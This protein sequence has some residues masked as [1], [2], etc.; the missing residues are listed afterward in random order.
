MKKI[1]ND[2]AYFI[3]NPDDYRSLAEQL[4]PK[5]T[6]L[7]SNRVTFKNEIHRSSRFAICH[8][9][10]KKNKTSYTVDYDDIQSP[11]TS[12]QKKTNTDPKILDDS[13]VK[14]L[15]ICFLTDI[16]D[17]T[18]VRAEVKLIQTDVF[19][20]TFNPH[21][22]SQFRRL[23]RINYLATVILSASGIEGGNMQLFHSEN[24]KIGP[25]K[26]IEELPTES[27]VGYIVDERPQRIFHGMKS[28]YELDKT[29][30]RSALLIR[31]F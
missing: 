16:Q 25:F 8:F 14:D 11:I 28:A 12:H 18:I 17:E 9:H 30:H 26:L 15:L 13:I 23:R 31:F 10:I 3:I 24:D 20:F 19:P 4:L 29:A 27:G 22:D 21:R 1:C 2:R 7:D 5:L 6:Q